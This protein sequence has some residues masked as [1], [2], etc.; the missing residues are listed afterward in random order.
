MMPTITTPDLTAGNLSLKAKYKHL[1][2]ILKAMERVVIAFSGGVD[3]TLL[4]KVA[5]DVLGEDSVLAVTALSAT[6]P[7]HEREDAIKFASEIGVSHKLVKTSELELPE[8][9]SN[10]ENKCYICKKSRFG[11]LV[12]LAR[13]GGF[14]HVLDG[15]NREDQ[16]DFRPGIRAARELGVRSP[17]SE[18]GFFKE[19]IR[20]LSK[21]LDLSSWNKLS[22]ACLASRIPYHSI[23]TAEKLKQVDEGEAFLRDLGFSG[24]LRVRHHGEIARLELDPKEIGRLFEASVQSRVVSYFRALGFEFVA[25]DLEGYVM[26]SLNRSLD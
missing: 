11:Y 13:E 3:S 22:S 14:Y 15:G 1:R 12:R 21:S 5:R 18:A 23:I 4:L 17:L 8:F 6:T 20:L 7:S 9:V 25:L 24:Q 19:E 10:P 26:G 16:L 2:E